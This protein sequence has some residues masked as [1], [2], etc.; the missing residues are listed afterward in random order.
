MSARGRY[1]ATVVSVPSK[2]TSPGRGSARL[3]WDCASMGRL[4]D[5]DRPT[6]SERLRTELGEEL[7]MLLLVTLR[8]D[9]PSAASDGTVGAA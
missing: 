3:L 2:F 8:A 1:R 6:A 7:T 5:E 4:L 9:R